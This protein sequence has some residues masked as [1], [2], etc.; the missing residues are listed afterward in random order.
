MAIV[1]SM[2]AFFTVSWAPAPP[3]NPTTVTISA[4]FDLTGGTFPNLIFTGT[5]TAEG[6]TSGTATGT[7]TM[8]ANFNVN[9]KRIHCIWTLTDGTGTIT[10]REDCVFASST[11][12]GRWEIVSGTGAY[13]NLRGNGSSL[14]PDRGDGKFWEILTGSIR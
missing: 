9:S 14:M 7:A 5:F 8:D 10:L 3:H 4:P 1:L 12:Q 13:A 6:L 2:I 11:W